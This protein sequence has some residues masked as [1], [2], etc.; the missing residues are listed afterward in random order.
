MRIARSALII[1]LVVIL[2]FSALQS[3]MI[4]PGAAT[5]G[6]PDAVVG[7]SDEYELVELKSP[8]GQRI[9]AVFGKALG[10][11]GTTHPD[12]A[13]QPTI[14]WFY[15]NGMCMANCMDEFE[16]LRR[17]GCNVCIPEFLGYGMSEGKPSEA[18]VYQTAYA[19]WDYLMG[20]EDVDK[21]KVIV[22][23]WSLGSAA[24]IELA[25]NKPVAGLMVFSAF[26]SMKDMARRV[27]PWAPTG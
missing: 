7:R 14:V 21:S 26:T 16:R 1:Y 5:Q 23:G 10:P 19:A 24:A 9:A 6:H 22:A 17:L 25:S 2:V 27:L 4:F 12:A 3:W 15:G 8:A 13:H 20:R 11:G 18:A